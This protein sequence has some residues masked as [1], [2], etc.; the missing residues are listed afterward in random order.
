MKYLLFIFLLLFL[1]SCALRERAGGEVITHRQDPNAPP[2]ITINNGILQLDFLTATAE[3]VLTELSTGRIFRSTPEG[4]SDCNESA[5]IERFYMQSLLLMEYQNRSSSTWTEDAYRF[6]V[7]G[8]TFTQAVVDNGIEVYFTIG[9]IM[10][11]FHIPDAVY[12]ERFYVFLDEMARRDRLQVLNIYSDS[13]N[14][15]GVKIYTLREDIPSALRGMVQ[16]ILAEAGYTYDDWVAD[17]AYFGLVTEIDQAAFNVTMR[18]TLEDNAM[19]VTIPFDEINYHPAFMPTHLTV[20]PYFGAGHATDDGY[21][22]LP[23]GSGSLM[24]FDTVR[25]NQNPFTSR[26]YGWD[27]AIMRTMLIRDNR[28]AFPVFG[29][30]RNG[31]TFAAIIDEGASYASVHAE[32]AGMRAPWNRVHPT[33]RLLH[34]AALDVA[35]R[36]GD[37]LLMHEWELPPGEQ[38]VIRYTVTSTP[39][40]VGMA[41]AFRD[42]LQARFPQFNDRVDAPVTAVVEVLGAAL[43]PQHLLG[44]PVDRP[45]ALTSFNETTDMMT[46]MAAKGW[47]NLHIQMRGAHNKSIDHEIPTGFNRIRQLGNRR[48]FD[49]MLNTASVLGYHFYI[50][51]DFMFM[52]GNRW[53]N[54]F[55]PNRDA[56]RQANRS[57]MEH[58]GFSPVYFGQLGAMSVMSDPIIVARPEFMINTARN[59]VNDAA[60]SG[61]NNIAFRSMAS[62]LAGDFHEDRHVS[63]EASMHMRVDLLRELSD[64]GTGVWLNYGFSYGVPFADVITGM[65]LTDQNFN[66]TSMHVPFYAIVLHGLVPFAGRPINLA[67]DYS[68]HLLNTVE[69]GASLFFSFMDAPTADLQVS[70]YR[71]YFSNEFGRWVGVA[72]E[73]Y[74]RHAADFGHLYNQLIIDHQILCRTGVTVTVYEDGTRVYVNTTMADFN[75]TVFVPAERYLVV[76]G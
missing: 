69:S 9:N 38:I 33:F 41:H 31:A 18:F 50:E 30:Y 75:G 72:D 48:A 46:T 66:V 19:L 14:D 12:A 44:F 71:R 21:L 70:R 6:S 17:M 59:F 22:F 10:E 45:F 36:T 28:A 2:V 43:T 67:E 40:Y 55:S 1:S 27:E 49:N 52:R 37:R 39:G 20:M 11:V 25:G 47:S 56:A 54:G 16:D 68:H 29:V 24:F 8:G 15:E 53:F 58:N 76:R 64:R 61:V 73:L 35:G 57:R 74:Q 63:R 26:V 42:F 3:I 60:D 4:A 7:R 5:A 51:G 13:I 23:D 34:G 65:P 32:P 62:A